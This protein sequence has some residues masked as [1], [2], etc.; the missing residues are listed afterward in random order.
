M[1]DLRAGFRRGLGG[2]GGGFIRGREIISWI[3]DVVD[4]CTR[5]EV[6]ESLSEAS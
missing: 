6:S 2:E 3:G 1:R 5:F 4:P